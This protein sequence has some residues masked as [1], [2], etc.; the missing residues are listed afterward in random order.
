MATINDKFKAAYEAKK[1]LNEAVEKSERRHSDWLFC[2]HVCW[3]N[4]K[5][6]VWKIDSDPRK[7]GV[8]SFGIGDDG[9]QT[10][11]LG[12]YDDEKAA[13]EKAFEDWL[14]YDVGD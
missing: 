12:G 10:L 5:V 1:A 4:L 7:K 9:W 6:A 11:D 14:A 2:V 8:V 13:V 3:N